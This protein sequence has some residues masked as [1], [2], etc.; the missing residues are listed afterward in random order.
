MQQFQSTGPANWIADNLTA[1]HL[2]SGGTAVGTMIADI[3]R[4]SA[5][6]AM[7]NAGMDF[8]IIDNEHGMWTNQAISDLCGLAVLLKLTPIVRVADL[9][10]SLIAQS[11]DA[12]AQGLVF[13]RIDNAEQVR[14]V[15]EWAR[16]PPHGVRGNA[17]WRA[18][19]NWTG[20]S[21]VDAMNKHNQ[22]TLLIFQIET[23]D[24]VKN[25]EAIISTPGC[26]GILVGPNDL[27]INLGTPDNWNSDVMQSAMN[28]V[29]ELCKKHNVIPGIHVSDTNQSIEY[30]KKGYRLVSAN[31]EMG[32]MQTAAQQHV[33][34]V[35]ASIGDKNIMKQ[36]QTSSK[37]YQLCKEYIVF[38]ESNELCYNYCSHLD[39]D[40]ILTM[41]RVVHE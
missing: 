31:S 16:Y 22:Q 38:I 20:G 5:I 30:Y 11:L 25:M 1:A 39:E 12:G 15:V 28:Q 34:V 17:Q 18:Y 26:D 41:N 24:S 40:D 14:Q 29:V 19:T 35:K 10:Y 3:N 36:Q 23:A 21:V 33:N 9:T 27:S 7:K 8:V 2:R 6:H 37:S 32:F 4:P 13:P